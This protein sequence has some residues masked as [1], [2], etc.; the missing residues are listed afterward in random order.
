MK[1]NRRQA[2]AGIGALAAVGSAKGIPIGI[3]SAVPQSGG[4]TFA[5]FISPSANPA[6]D[7]T[8]NTG[9][10]SHPWSLNAL[11]TQGST[12]AGKNVG[13]IGDQ[14]T[15]DCLSIY[16]AANGGSTLG[17]SNTSGTNSPAFNIAGGSS[18]SPTYV[19][20]CNSSGVYSPRIAILDCGSTSLSQSATVNP[21][22]NPPI[23]CYPSTVGYVTIDGFVIQNNYYRYLH[24][25]YDGG[26]QSPSPRCPGIIIQNCYFTG[27]LYNEITA[28]NPTFITLYDCSGAIVQNNLADA[29]VDDTTSRTSCIEQWGSVNSI[30]QYN[31]LTPA[32]AAAT[33]GI[34]IKNENN[35]NNTIRYNYIDLTPA[36]TNASGGIC[37]DDDAP[38][39]LVTTSVDYVY[40]NI[41]ISDLP[42]FWSAINVDSWPNYT[43]QEQWYNN[44]LVGDPGTSNG[45]FW[46][47]FAAPGNITFYNNILY[48]TSDTGGF[49]GMLNSNDGS[50]A[51]TGSFSLIDY[52]LYSPLNNGMSAYAANGNIPAA[53]TLVT[54]LSS[55]QAQLPTGAT[56]RD[57]HSTT[58]A[59]TFVGG[60]PTYPAQYYEL[61]S[62]SAGKGAGSSNGQTSGTAIDMG[63]WGGTDVNTGLPIAQIGCNFT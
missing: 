54:S 22:G 55:W 45:L 53:P 39:S 14:G 28:E 11:N 44:T 3:G 56:G 17:S 10:L 50:S 52:N 33:A 58:T 13:I 9:S 25:G 60:S 47:R 37:I 48:A 57:A 5:Y 8:T 18:G 12:Y 15:Y 4:P 36:G 62:G 46:C 63:A 7:G 61:S 38:N 16:I 2:L 40:N 43:H 24:C 35:N 34:F 19:A 6:N 41:V 23:G 59:P 51:G 32:S 21:G 30:I 31:T 26:V 27:T 49:R 20:S 42:V 1:M 29:S